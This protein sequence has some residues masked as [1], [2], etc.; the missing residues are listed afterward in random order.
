LSW[1]HTILF[2]FAAK[3]QRKRGLN[4]SSSKSGDS[5]KIASPADIGVMLAEEAKKMGHQ[6]RM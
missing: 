1:F 5:P 6:L 3:S 4:T 2:P